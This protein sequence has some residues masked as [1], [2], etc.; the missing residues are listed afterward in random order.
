M[1]RRSVTDVEDWLNRRKK[2]F[3]GIPNKAK[4]KHKKDDDSGWGRVDAGSEEEGEDDG[5]GCGRVD[6]G[7]EEEGEDREEEEGED[8][9]EEEGEDREEEEGEDREEEEWWWWSRLS[10]LMQRLIG[11]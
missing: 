3:Y 5:S 11:Q 8:R 10:K 9:E 6:A 2:W 1:A 7:S 4:Y